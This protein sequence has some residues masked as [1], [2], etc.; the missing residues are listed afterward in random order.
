[1]KKSPSKIIAAKRI[2]VAVAAVCATMAMP[3]F[4]ADD[5]KGLMDLLLKKGVI[6]QQEYDQNIKAAEDAA[7]N[8]AFKEKRLDDDVAKANNFIQK[9]ANAGVVMKNGLGIESADGENSIKFIGRVH[10]DYRN[11]SSN[12]AVDSYQDKMEI[13]RGRFGFQGA[14]AKD[15]SYKIFANYGQADG[16][17]FS[18]KETD[19]DEGFI[20]YKYASGLQFQV[21][22]FKMPFS[23]EQLTSS[24]NIDF[25][26]RSIG[27]Q[28]EGELIP[29][30]EVGAMLHG[31]PVAGT[32]YGLALSRGRGNKDSSNDKPDF[33]GRVSANI[34]ALAGMKNDVIHV[35]L[36]YSTGE[37]KAIGASS[38]TSAKTE[39]RESDKFF[40]STVGVLS[41]ATRTREGLE[42]AY[43]TGPFKLQFENSKVKYDN[44][45]GTD[46]SYQAN[47]LQA[48]W[49]VTGENHNYS[50]SSGT[51]GWIKPNSKFSSKGGTGALQIGVRYSKFDASNIAAAAGFTNSANAMTYGITWIANDNVRLMLNF[52]STDFKTPIGTGTAVRTNERAIM[53]RAQVSF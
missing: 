48:I 9:N 27:G 31:S 23:L 1:M 25:M 14:F 33:V 43:A 53:T 47:Y 42:L 52:V 17:G 46:P 5:M 49:N 39:A 19:L 40:T 26:E 36:G 6:T 15:F 34:G 3:A 4:A 21:G 2:A 50:N 20:N 51:F 12:A 35:G 22:K 41:G 29:A 24:N 18:S 16:V 32:S 45:T 44:Q 8:K 37:V 11:Y 28:I 10:M 38:I 30:K 7:E 13:R